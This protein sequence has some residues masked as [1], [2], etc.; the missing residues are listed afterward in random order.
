[1][2]KAPAKAY[3]S[4]SWRSQAVSSFRALLTQHPLLGKPFPPV[5]P[6]SPYSLD[7]TM[8]SFLA[9]FTRRNPWTMPSFQC[10]SLP[11]RLPIGLGP[12][13]LL[14]LHF[15]PLFPFFTLHIWPPCRSS[16]LPFSFSVSEKHN[17]TKHFQGIYSVFPTWFNS[18]Q[19]SPPLRG[20]V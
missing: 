13:L 1:M 2:N 9:P 12:W 8:K 10:H 6:D 18:D 7:K 11:H 20:Y 4:V 17:K 16:K 5:P 14:K 3:P 15:L 19:R